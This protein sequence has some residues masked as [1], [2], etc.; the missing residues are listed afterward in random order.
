MWTIAMVWM[1]SDPKTRTYVQRRT[2]EGMTNKEIHRCLN[3][4]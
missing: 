4:T 1:R 3:A 2:Q